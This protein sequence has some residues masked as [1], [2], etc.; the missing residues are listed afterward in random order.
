MNVFW[1]GKEQYLP[2]N[3]IPRELII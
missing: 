2:T 3:N 1:N